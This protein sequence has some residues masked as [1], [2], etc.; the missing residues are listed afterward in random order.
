M[1]PG[2]IERLASTQVFPLRYLGL[3]VQRLP[4][5]LPFKVDK[6][7]SPLQVKDAPALFP[8]LIDASRYSASYFGSMTGAVSGRKF[9]NVGRVYLR[10]Q[11]HRVLHPEDIAELW[12]ACRASELLNA[13]TASDLQTAREPFGVAGQVLCVL[14]NDGLRCMAATT[15]LLQDHAAPPCL[16]Y[17][18][19]RRIHGENMQTMDASQV[20]LD[21]N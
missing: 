14:C 4:S 9:W 19:G 5:R 21:A 20:V 16:A 3:P 1:A 13:D 15:M 12:L 8:M 2:S 6:W 7:L 10:S 17:E 18:H 11:A